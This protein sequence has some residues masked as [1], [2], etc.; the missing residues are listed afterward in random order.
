MSA[1]YNRGDYVIVRG[2]FEHY[3]DD[4]KYLKVRSEFRGGMWLAEGWFDPA[5]LEPS[6][7]SPPAP[8]GNAAVVEA[9]RPFLFHTFGRCPNHPDASDR[10][11]FNRQARDCGC[12]G[13]ICGLDQALA[14]AERGGAGGR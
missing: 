4:G 13:C 6:P 3:S 1:R 10:R 12:A 14:L 5:D 9:L 8:A 11:C 7:T 2:V